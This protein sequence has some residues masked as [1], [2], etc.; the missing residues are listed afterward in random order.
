MDEGGDVA[1]EFEEIRNFLEEHPESF[2]VPVRAFNVDEDHAYFVY[3]VGF[4]GDYAELHH[5]SE[6]VVDFQ[7]FHDFEMREKE[8]KFVEFMRHY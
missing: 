2:D 7:N 4:F 8:E 5:F 1:L 6:I 3:C